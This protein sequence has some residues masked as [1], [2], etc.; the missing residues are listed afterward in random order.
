MVLTGIKSL[1][2]RKQQLESDLRKPLILPDESVPSSQAYLE[3]KSGFEG[4][5]K[6]L[7]IAIFGER[8][9]FCGSRYDEKQLLLH[10]KDGRPHH[11]DLTIKEKFFRTLDPKDWVFLCNHEHRAIHWALNTLGLKWDDLKRKEDGAE[12]EI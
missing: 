1:P 8:C 10:R 12:G 9:H 5:E 7:R 2:L 4:T 11:G 3:M 6:E